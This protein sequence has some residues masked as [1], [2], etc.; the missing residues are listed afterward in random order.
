MVI[1][2]IRGQWK[3]K[4]AGLHEFSEQNQHDLGADQEVAAVLGGRCLDV[5][6]QQHARSS[7][8]KSSKSRDSNCS[9]ENIKIKCESVTP[10]SESSYDGDTAHYPSLQFLAAQGE[11]VK[12]KEE[13]ERGIDVNAMDKQ[14]LT[15]LMWA[16]AHRQKAASNLLL[17]NHADPN[18]EGLGGETPLLFASSQGQSDIIDQL[19]SHGA[20]INHIDMNGGTALMYAVFGGF[21]EIAKKLLEYGADMTIKN[22]NDETCYSLALTLGNKAA[23][24]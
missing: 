9:M 5:P 4:M 13:I 18:K 3:K 6:V 15:P 22:E 8:S 17:E 14:G 2:V 16:A 24:Y 12:I 1:Q 19:L 23:A 20:K 10:V 11:V 21:P 7:S